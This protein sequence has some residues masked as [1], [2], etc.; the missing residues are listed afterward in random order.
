MDKE[1]VVNKIMD[2]LN[3]YEDIDDSLKSSN[4]PFWRDT[5][6]KV[7]WEHKAFTSMERILKN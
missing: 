1:Q 5:S 6:L 2:E 3:K 4:D 7:A